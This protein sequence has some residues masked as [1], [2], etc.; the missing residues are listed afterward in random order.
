MMEKQTNSNKSENTKQVVLDLDNSHSYEHSC[1][2]VG[3]EEIAKAKSDQIKNSSSEFQ[4]KRDLK[5]QRKK[6]GLQEQ[7]NYIAI[8]ES[9]INNQSKTTGNDKLLYSE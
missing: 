1:I 4:K 3:I 9:P 5:C 7:N 2:I 8:N 6:S